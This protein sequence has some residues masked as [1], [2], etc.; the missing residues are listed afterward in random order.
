MSTGQQ[1]SKQKVEP[2]KERKLEKGCWANNREWMVNRE[3]GEN[4]P[5]EVHL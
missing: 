4:A 3:T 5:L 1:I 2:G